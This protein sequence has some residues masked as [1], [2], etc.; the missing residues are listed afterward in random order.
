[1]PQSA[2]HLGSRGCDGYRGS[3]LNLLSGHELEQ[4]C[5]LPVFS[6]DRPTGVRLPSTTSPATPR[7]RWPRPSPTVALTPLPRSPLAPGRMPHVAPRRPRPP[8][9]PPHHSN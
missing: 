2:L 3:A 9:V 5:G 8:C 4:S 1:T 6:I 7:L